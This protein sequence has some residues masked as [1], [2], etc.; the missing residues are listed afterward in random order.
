MAVPGN[1]RKKHK[2]G[3]DTAKTPKISRYCSFNIARSLVLTLLKSGRHPAAATA[4]HLA[5]DLYEHA[6]EWLP[7]WNLFFLSSSFFSSVVQQRVGECACDWNVNV[8]HQEISRLL[9]SVDVYS[10]KRLPEMAGSSISDDFDDTMWKGGGVAMGLPHSLA[11]G[12]AD[13]EGGG[14]EGC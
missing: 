3:A 1:H 7:S 10:Y 9:S 11:I 4:R 12:T 8:T 5:A 6:A 13:I 14:V 2:S